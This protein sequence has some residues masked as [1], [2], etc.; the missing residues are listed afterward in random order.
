MVDFIVEPWK[1]FQYKFE[2]VNE[3][4]V[5]EFDDDLCLRAV[6]G[7]PSE[8][9]NSLVGQVVVGV[10]KLAL[11]DISVNERLFLNRSGCGWIRCP[12]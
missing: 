7:D 1:N 3:D 5:V 2:G 9:Q 8:T 10:R 11:H 12:A 4:V 6:L